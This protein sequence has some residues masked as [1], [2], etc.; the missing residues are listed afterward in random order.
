MKISIH[1]TFVAV[2]LL[3]S[4]LLAEEP[5]LAIPGSILYENKL[6]EAPGPEWKAAKGKWESADGSLR[7]SELPEDKHGAV[8]RLNRK[9]TDFV[10]EA[11]FC[12]SGAKSTTLSINAEKDH[13]ARIAI[14]PNLVTVR[15]DDNDHAGPDK[16]ITFA[17]FPAKFE[18]GTWHKIRLEMVGDVLLGQVDDLVAW[19]SDPLFATPKVAPGFTAAGQSI[20][21]RNFTVR[22]AT[23]NPNW[24]AVKATLPKP[25]EKVVRQVPAAGAGK[26]K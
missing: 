4:P 3:V 16:A 17:V 2:G 11:E 22:A 7:G 26:K 19:G 20:Q 6:A 10:I 25:G 1:L 21:W 24:E 9:F 18:P 15:R 8:I 5:K 13:M 14:T 23:L 12:F